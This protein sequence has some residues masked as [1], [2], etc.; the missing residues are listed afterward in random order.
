MVFFGIIARGLR[1]DGDIGFADSFDDAD[2]GVGSGEDFPL[3]ALVA[4]I[5]GA[6]FENEVHQVVFGGRFLF[7]EDDLAFAVEHPGDASLLSHV[8][9]VLGKGMADIADGTVA[10]VG[11]DLDDDR[12]AAGSVPFVGD[13]LHLF[14]AEFAAATHNGA[15]DIFRRHGNRFGGDDGGAEAGVG[16]GVAAVAS[17][18]DDFFDE[19]RED[20]A[21]LGVEGS[22]LMLDCCPFGMA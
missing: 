11:G 8:S 6:D 13:F 5:V 18:D 2:I 20:F 22:L 15:L 21:A 14:A 1:F 17:G 7:V 16:V 4:Q 12:G 9:A 10:V 19:A 3:V